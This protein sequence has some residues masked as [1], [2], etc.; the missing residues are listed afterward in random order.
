MSI[1]Y[2]QKKVSDKYLCPTEGK[3]SVYINIVVLLQA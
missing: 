2:F 3:L 1:K